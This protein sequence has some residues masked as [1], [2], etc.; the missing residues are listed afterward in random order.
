ML[1]YRPGMSQP[2]NHTR[3]AGIDFCLVQGILGIGLRFYC[4]LLRHCV[5]IFLTGNYFICLL[6]LYTCSIASD[7]NNGCINFV[8]G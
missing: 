5:H 1:Q 4:T 3:D 8:D 7:P 6:I 2:C